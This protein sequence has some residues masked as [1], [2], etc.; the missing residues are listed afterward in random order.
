MLRCRDKYLHELLRTS[1]RL[2]SSLLDLELNSSAICRLRNSKERTWR[3]SNQVHCRAVCYWAEHKLIG[4]TNSVHVVQRERAEGNP[5]PDTLM[6]DLDEKRVLDVAANLVCSRQSS[7]SCKCLAP[8]STWQPHFRH[9]FPL[10]RQQEDPDA[11]QQI[12][13]FPSPVTY[14]YCKGLGQSR[15]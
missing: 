13:R 8:R 12:H 7:N 4:Q 2:V 10:P 11:Q 1:G 14:I 6:R 5:H 9:R 3:N 15:M